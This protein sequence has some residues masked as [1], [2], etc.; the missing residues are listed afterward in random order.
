[1]E[2][3]ADP[4]PETLNP[5]LLLQD[6]TRGIYRL[7]AI[8]GEF[9]D[10]VLATQLQTTPHDINHVVRSVATE[11]FPR[12][13]NVDLVLNLTPDLPPV[14]A[15]EAKLKRAFSELI[16]NSIDFQPHGGMLTIHL[17]GA[18]RP[19]PCVT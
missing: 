11:S 10:F 8:L 2:T 1:M 17:L 19:K 7:E 4:K 3:S 15:D 9:R 12:N 14:L 6:I 5:M 13:S 16:E 18:P